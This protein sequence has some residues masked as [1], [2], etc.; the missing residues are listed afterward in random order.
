MITLVGNKKKKKIV[1]NKKSAF[2]SED[3]FSASFGL[4]FTLHDHISR[5]EKKLFSASFWKVF[6]S[7]FSNRKYA[8]G[9][10]FQF[11]HFFFW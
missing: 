5:Q 4:D 11:F 3:Q 8:R 10:T 2:C 9:L 6:P 7:G 1:G